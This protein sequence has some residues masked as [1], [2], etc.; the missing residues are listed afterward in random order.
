MPGGVH[1]NVSDEGATAND[2]PRQASSSSDHN[3]IPFRNDVTRYCRTRKGLVNRPLS[4]AQ[5]RQRRFEEL[6]AAVRDYC[7]MLYEAAVDDSVFHEMR[8]MRRA[9]ARGEIHIHIRNAITGDMKVGVF[10]RGN[11]YRDLYRDTRRLFG[12]PTHAT[13]VSM[14]LET[15]T[16]GIIE[17]RSTVKL[18]NEHH[19]QELRCYFHQ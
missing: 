8:R 7:T 1:H 18:D 12:K 5:C 15:T 17:S 6:R 10:K 9:A 14:R 16:G 13:T 3:H 4:R 19:N 2:Q 11:T